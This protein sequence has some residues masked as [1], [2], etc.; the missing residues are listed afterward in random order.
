M[1]ILGF[2][3]GKLGETN[4]LR[5]EINPKKIFK[6]EVLDEKNIVVQN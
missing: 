5:H 4:A 3:F 2:H 6:F 1:I